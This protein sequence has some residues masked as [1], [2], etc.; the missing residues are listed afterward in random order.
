MLLA[1]VGRRTI[2]SPYLDPPDPLLLESVTPAQIGR[3]RDR[4]AGTSSEQLE[5]AR[6]QWE[7]TAGNIM[8]LHNAGVRIG[9]GSDGGGQG[10]DRFIGF[11]AHTELENMVA[12]GMTPAEAI[13]A[14]TRNGAE[15]L[16]LEEDLG[17]VAVGKSADFIVLNANPLDEI[18]N[19]REIDRVYLRGYE[20]DRARL[21]AM[22]ADDAASSSASVAGVEEDDAA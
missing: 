11:T 13:V 15:I 19:S 20:V 10:G 14:G 1:Q 17:T 18:T 7:R 8:K 21:R 2:H 9:I 16:G 12:A 22:W 3:L 6:Q 4:V 5:R